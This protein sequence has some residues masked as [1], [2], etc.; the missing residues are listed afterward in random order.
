MRAAVVLR[1]LDEL[2]VAQTAAALRCSEGTVKS[3]TA[4]GL[5]QLRTALTAPGLSPPVAGSDRG[6]RPDPERSQDRN[7]THDLPRTP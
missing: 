5:A 3:Q 1:H 2:S 6:D 4:R 7:R